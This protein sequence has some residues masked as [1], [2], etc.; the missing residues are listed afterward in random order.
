LTRIDI[1]T[2]GGLPFSLTDIPGRDAFIGADVND[3]VNVYDLSPGF[4]NAK[5]KTLTVPRLNATCW[6]VYSPKTGT[7]FVSDNAGIISEVQLA[8]DLTPSVLTVRHRNIERN[9]IFIHSAW[10][11]AI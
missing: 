5:I 7:Y 4:K 1:P 3:G 10:F 11:P 6:T 8:D 9:I 2:P